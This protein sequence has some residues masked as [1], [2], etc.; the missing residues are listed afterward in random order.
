[1]LL[2]AKLILMVTMVKN[3]PL[4]HLTNFITFLTFL[5]G[6]RFSFMIVLNVKQ[7]NIFLLNPKIFLLLYLFMKTPLILITEYQWILRAP[8]LLLLTI[9][10]IFLLSLMLSATLLLLT[11]LLTL[12]LVMQFKLFFIIRLQN[13]DRHNI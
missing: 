4:K 5:C 2:S 10:H 7:I 8:F 13:L 12:L 6:S 3:S 9:P 1:M 11:Q